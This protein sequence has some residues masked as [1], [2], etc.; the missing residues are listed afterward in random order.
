MIFREDKG[1]LGLKRIKEKQKK[2]AFEMNDKSIYLGESIES[3]EEVE[4][5]T[6]NVRRFGQE[7]KQP[8][9]RFLSFKQ[10]DIRI[11]SERIT[12]TAINTRD[13]R[14]K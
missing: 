8:D 9:V 5:H 12:C 2:Q 14:H 4:Q 11:L 7:R 1:T 6:L 3:N 10:Y 13:K